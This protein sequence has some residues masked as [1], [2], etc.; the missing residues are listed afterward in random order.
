MRSPMT[1]AER[2]RAWLKDAVLAAA[3]AALLWA[4]ALGF[5]RSLHAQ[6]DAPADDKEK[7]KPVLSAA[8]ERKLE[9]A[10]ENDTA[11]LDRFDAIMKEIDV[12]KVRVLR[13]PQT[14]P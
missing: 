12:V 11:I 6:D 3:A 9:Q 5:E 4:G 2:R 13:K 14:L 1:P 10:I 8:G 7:P